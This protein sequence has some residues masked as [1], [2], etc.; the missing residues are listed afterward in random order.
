MKTE[1]VLAT[2]PQWKSVPYAF[3][4]AKYFFHSLSVRSKIQVFDPKFIYASEG[5]GE[6]GF[7]LG[8]VHSSMLLEYLT[9]TIQHPENDPLIYNST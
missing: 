3:R 5:N 4:R 9:P 2:F 7:S 1:V 8:M 6:R